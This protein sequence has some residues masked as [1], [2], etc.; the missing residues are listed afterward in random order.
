MRVQIQDH[1]DLSDIL[2]SLGYIGKEDVAKAMRIGASYGADIIEVKWWD[3]I[4]IRTGRAYAPYAKV[5]QAAT[6]NLSRQSEKRD[7]DTVRPDGV[8]AR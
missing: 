4:N 2:L 8:S 7:A 1:R 5:F 6:E 3:L